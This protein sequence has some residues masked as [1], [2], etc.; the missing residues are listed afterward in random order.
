MILDNYSI[1][2]SALLRSFLSELDISARH[3][4]DLDLPM[5]RLCRLQEGNNMVQLRQDMC[6]ALSLK[7]EAL[8]LEAGRIF[9]TVRFLEFYYEQQKTPRKPDWE[10]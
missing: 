9:Q 2:P 8:E 4:S 10:S 1:N 7:P 6:R 5:D 3:A